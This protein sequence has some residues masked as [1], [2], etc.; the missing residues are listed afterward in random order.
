[1]FDGV[2]WVEEDKLTASDGTT[3]DAFAWRVALSG[4]VAVVG[5]QL[6]DDAGDASGS[7]YVFRYDPDT[8]TWNEEQKLTAADAAAGDSFGF[9]VATRGDL[10]LVGA[11]RDDDNGI[12][13]G[14]A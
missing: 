4:D 11:W 7:A 3:F 12:D 13:A 10:T 9:S 5:A 2:C 14:S 1:R 6:D 8:G